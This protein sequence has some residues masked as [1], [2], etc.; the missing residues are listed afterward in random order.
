MNILAELEGLKYPDEMVTR[1][2]FKNGL[3]Q[4]SGRVLEL[5]CGNAN[6]LT[7]F[8]AYGWDVAGLDISPALLGQGSRNFQRLGLSVPRLVAA[9]LNDPIPELGAVDVLLLPSSL[10]YVR[11]D[12]A[13]Q[14]MAEIAQTLAPGALIFCRFRTHDDYRYGCGEDLGENCFRLTISETSEL[15]CTIAFYSLEAMLT[16]LAPCDLDPASLQVMKLAFDN[17]GKEDQM[18]HNDEIVLWGR[19]RL[20]GEPGKKTEKAEVRPL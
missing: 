2:F 10:Y 5:G 16:L 1:F 8:A 15:G 6:N 11:V 17:L 4:R 13:R 20:S 3:Q 18:I 7:L 19:S 9:D 14:I 12:R